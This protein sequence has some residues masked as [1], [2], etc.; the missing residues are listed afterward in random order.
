VQIVSVD[1]GKRLAE[2]SLRTVENRFG[3]LNT[4]LVHW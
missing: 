2:V 4:V 3:P 1:D